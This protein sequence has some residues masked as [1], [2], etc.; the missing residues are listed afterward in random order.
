MKKFLFC[1]LYIFTAWAGSKVSPE[2][3]YNIDEGNSE[4]Q[5]REALGEP[6]AIK[7]L[8]KDEREFEYIEKIFVDNIMMEIHHY[9]FVLKN[10][11]IISKRVTQ[12]KFEGRPLLERNAFDLQTS[13]NDEKPKE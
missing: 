12:D 4:T 6:Y 3:Y 11:V 10:G 8:S 1:L 2:A 13:S 9:Y 5:L 7:C